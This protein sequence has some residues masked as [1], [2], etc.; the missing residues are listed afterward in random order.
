MISYPILKNSGKKVLGR[1]FESKKEGDG[2]GE[3]I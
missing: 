2:T 1:I 3:Q